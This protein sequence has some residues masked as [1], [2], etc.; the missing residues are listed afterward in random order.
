MVAQGVECIRGGKQKMS[1]LI[2]Y[3]GDGVCLSGIG[4][5]CYHF[6]KQL[7]GM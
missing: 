5:F 4:L 7:L 1:E 2:Y 6:G 3:I